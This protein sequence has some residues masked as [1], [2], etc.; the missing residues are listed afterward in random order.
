MRKGDLKAGTVYATLGEGGFSVTK[1]YV[2]DE[3]T[4]FIMAYRE[5][6]ESIPEDVSTADLTPFFFAPVEREGLGGD[7]KLLRHEPVS[8]TEL[9][10]YR[11]HLDLQSKGYE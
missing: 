10:T 8:E 2:L 6:F 1:V 5:Q 7:L 9:Q 4:A 11:D 3:S